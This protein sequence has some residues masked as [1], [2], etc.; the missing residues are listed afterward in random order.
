MLENMAAARIAADGGADRVQDYY[1]GTNVCHYR[2]RGLLDHRPVVTLKCGT[3]GFQLFWQNGYE[4]WP[5][6]ATRLCL[7]PDQRNRINY[8]LQ[9]IV[10]PGPKQPFDLE[11]FWHLNAEELAELGKDVP[12]LVIPDS[13]TPVVLSAGV[14]DFTTDQPGG[15]K[16]F[17]VNGTSS[18]VL[19]GLANSRR[20]TGRRLITSATRLRTLRAVAR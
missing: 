15:D 8:Q 18:Y 16:K 14:L 11:S 2:E 17:R 13:A 10:T 5:I 4:G 20:Y 3:N 19:I 12:G 6:T 7:S 9:L 1:H